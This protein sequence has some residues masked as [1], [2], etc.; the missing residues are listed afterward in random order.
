MGRP[1]GA[2]EGTGGAAPSAF[3]APADEALG[4]GGTGSGAA[5]ALGAPVDV[6][7][8]TDVLLLVPPA[9]A[10]AA[11]FGLGTPALGCPL[12]VEGQTGAVGGGVEGNVVF[13]FL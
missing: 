4:G 8:G 6:A 10:F 5:P 7:S 9:V 12:G 3:G 13:F 1:S 11:F 2:E